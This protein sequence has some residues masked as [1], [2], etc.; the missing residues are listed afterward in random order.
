MS[1]FP[2]NRIK[3]NLFTNGGELIIESS[4]KDYKGFYYTTFD[5]KSY[6]GRDNTTAPVVRLISK[7]KP[8]TQG[9]STIL[10]A[11]KN[12]A[13]QALKVLPFGK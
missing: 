12:T 7:P 9:K 10:D 6:I 3:T 5:N 11:I 8:R 13:Y 2:K 1:Y 4:K